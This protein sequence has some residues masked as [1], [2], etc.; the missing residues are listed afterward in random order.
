MCENIEIGGGGGKKQSINTKIKR[1]SHKEIIIFRRTEPTLNFCA[2]KKCEKGVLG[3]YM[4]L[5][6]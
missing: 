1:M 6:W 3:D 4:I 5:G 2:V